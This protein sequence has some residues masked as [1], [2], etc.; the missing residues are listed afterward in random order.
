M[1]RMRIIMKHRNI[2]SLALAALLACALFA[3]ACAEEDAGAATGAWAIR[4]GPVSME[5]NA[6]ARAAMD[7]APEGPDRRSV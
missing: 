5:Q 3:S 7:K 4:Q 2:I 6:Q 1:E